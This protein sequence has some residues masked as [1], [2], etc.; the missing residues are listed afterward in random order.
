MSYLKTS[1][2]SLKSF[3]LV[4]VSNWWINY[5]LLLFNINS[6]YGYFTPPSSTFYLSIKNLGFFYS[7]TIPGSVMSLYVEI[8]ERSQ[9]LIWV[10]LRRLI[11]CLKLFE[12]ALRNVDTFSANSSAKITFYFF[13]YFCDGNTKSP[14]TSVYLS[15]TEIFY[16]NVA[17]Y[18]SRWGRL[19]SCFFN[20]YDLITE[21]LLK[22]GC[23][24][25]CWGFLGIY[26]LIIYI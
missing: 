25:F 6:L 1:I 4:L 16:F 17:F 2:S 15:T 9:S 22:C 8:P 7:I 21:R 19:V 3:M 26:I 10:L 24:F 20:E 14:S 11:N 23:K 5:F 12:F 18:L 13:V